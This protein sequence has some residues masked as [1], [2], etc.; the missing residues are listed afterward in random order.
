M[1]YIY[2]LWL[3]G[4]LSSC[5]TQQIVPIFDNPPP[6]QD[7]N[8]YF[9][10]VDNDFDK[11]EGTW[12]FQDT[13]RE[14]TIKL[15]KEEAVDDNDG[16]YISDML[17]GEYL[18]K[19]NNVELVNTLSDINDPSITGYKH[20]IAGKFLINKFMNPECDDC[21]VSERRVKL[22]IN[23]PTNIDGYGLYYLKVCKR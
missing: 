3:I 10:D 22:T 2:I 12:E 6:I 4:V 5:K 16:S 21:T 19:E 9:K 15:E 8:S 1:R 18:Y 20:N 13:L 17:V 14:F 11:F 7:P 23:N